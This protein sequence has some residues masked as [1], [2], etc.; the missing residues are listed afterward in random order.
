MNALLDISVTLGLLVLLLF[1]VAVVTATARTLTYAAASVSCRHRQRSDSPAAK[2][3]LDAKI[4]QG[5]SEPQTR[6]FF[7]I[8]IHH[9]DV[10]VT[11]TQTSTLKSRHAI[12]WPG[13]PSIRSFLPIRFE[14]PGFVRGDSSAESL[15]WQIHN[16]KRGI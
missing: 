15:T 14:R 2:Q 11:R 6:P 12:N 5:T 7:G 13:P 3:M 16:A 8:L 1:L 10:K 4:V 9:P